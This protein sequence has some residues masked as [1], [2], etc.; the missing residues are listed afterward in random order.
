MP[1]CTKTI[2]YK[3]DSH[4]SSNKF[5]GVIQMPKELTHWIIADKIHQY[6]DD[7][8]L[9]A[10]IDKHR[11]LYHIG[12]VALDTPYYFRGKS[13]GVFEELA[14]SLHGKNQEDTFAPIVKVVQYY[15]DNVPPPVWAFLCGIISHIMTDGQFHP[16]VYFLTGNYYDPD[17][18]ARE[19][20]ICNH[21]KWEAQLDLYYSRNFM[22]M[23]PNLL[24]N[25][26]HTKTISDNDLISMLAV[27]YFADDS[28]HRNEIKSALKSHSFMT[29]CFS[30]KSIYNL[31]KMTN[32]VSGGKCNQNLAMFY[33]PQ[34]QLYLHSFK[35]SFKYRH[36]KT[37]E[38]RED[39]LQ[40]I[41][42]RAIKNTLDIINHWSQVKNRT[43]FLEFHSQVRGP[44]LE[45]GI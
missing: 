16:L 42:D 17:I 33:P 8:S 13:T 22:L 2:Q 25:C 3:S 23:K 41:E 24:A 20:A 35:S 11:A 30:K 15:G 31:I 7:S 28:L 37:G 4:C 21:R 38:E 34:E 18:Q 12:A 1:G 6:M 45:T 9:K 29:S 19:K 36:P 14:N 32:L 27:L 10:G 39:T 40:N 26:L 44:S 5:E 43:D